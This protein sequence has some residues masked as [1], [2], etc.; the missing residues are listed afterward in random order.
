MLTKASKA[1]IA[2]AGIFGDV[3]MTNFANV[4]EPL[5]TA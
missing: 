4:N 2:V 1:A 5:I 3:L